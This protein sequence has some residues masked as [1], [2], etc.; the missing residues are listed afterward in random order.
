MVKRS[1]VGISLIGVLGGLWFSLPPVGGLVRI[2]VGEGIDCFWHHLVRLL[3]IH[4][5]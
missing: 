3:E 4:V 2:K 1:L 5:R